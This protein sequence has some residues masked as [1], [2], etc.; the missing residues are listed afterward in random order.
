MTSICGLNSLASHT[1]QNCASLT[2]PATR[3][4]CMSHSGS[5]RPKQTPPLALCTANNK[6]P[7]VLQLCNALLIITPTCRALGPAIACAAQRV[8]HALCRDCRVHT[9]H[10]ESMTSSADMLCST[11]TQLSTHKTP[12]IHAYGYGSLPKPCVTP[13]GRQAGAY[14]TVG[15]Q[16]QP[17][18]PAATSQPLLLLAA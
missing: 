18:L 10:E 16:Q 17:H 14:C 15:K 3:H 13:T 8:S 4:C 7:L 6:S 9:L 11:H 2:S 12:A 5:P 1:F